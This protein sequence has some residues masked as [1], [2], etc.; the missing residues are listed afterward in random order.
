VSA[1]GDTSDND[2]DSITTTA[3]STL[4]GDT[5]VSAASVDSKSAMG[6]PVSAGGRASAIKNNSVFDDNTTTTTTSSAGFVKLAARTVRV[7]FL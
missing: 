7:L 1:G 4:R 2:T 5:S 6:G 3:S